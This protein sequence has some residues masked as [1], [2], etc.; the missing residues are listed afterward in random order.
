MTID[1]LGKALALVLND[2]R[3]LREEIE[4]ELSEMRAAMR[5]AA[6][7]DGPPVDHK[8]LARLHAQGLA[9]SDF[10]TKIAMSLQ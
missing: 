9:C 10:A 1:E 6:T 3:E 4:A 7:S 8:T 5:A 2:V